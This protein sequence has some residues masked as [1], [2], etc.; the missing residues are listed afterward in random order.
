MSTLNVHNL[1][2]L[3][4]EYPNWNQR[5]RIKKVDP[6]G[7]VLEGQYAYGGEVV[8][9]SPRYQKN[10]TNFRVRPERPAAF[11]AGWA[12]ENGL[13]PTPLTPE[14]A[15]TPAGL[16][17]LEPLFDTY[18]SYFPKLESPYAACDASTQPS[19]KVGFSFN[20]YQVLVEQI[21]SVKPVGGSSSTMARPV[22]GNPGSALDLLKK[23][24]EDMRS[25]TQAA[26]T[27]VSPAQ[28]PASPTSA[29][30]PTS[31]AKK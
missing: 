16:E 9:V 10:G 11:F 30:P 25:R 31:K 12:F 21:G 7:N 5:G 28:P 29:L 6:Q 24:I 2:S 20:V 3:R 17:M 27:A 13:L 15:E 23:K 19:L 1:A 8:R 14:E 18:K 22:V 26:P 4:R